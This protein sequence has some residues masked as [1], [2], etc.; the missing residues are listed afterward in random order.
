MI[1]KG[2][3]ATLAGQKCGFNDYSAFYRLYKKHFGTSPTAV[4]KQLLSPVN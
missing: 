4:K 3:S 2:E 1:S